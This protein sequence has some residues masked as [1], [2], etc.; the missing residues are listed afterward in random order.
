MTGLGIARQKQDGHIAGTAQNTNRLRQ[1]KPTSTFDGTA[2][3]ADA[4]TREA[5]E[6][7][8]PVPD[9]P[10]IREYDFG[11]PVGKGPNGGG[12]SV[13]RVHKDQKDRIH[14]HPSGRETS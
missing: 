6:R 5:W 1:G 9:R 13:V 2:D 10:D 11:R 4:L 7:G 3:E 12:Q 8:S 14:G